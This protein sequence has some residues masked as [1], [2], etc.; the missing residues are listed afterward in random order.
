MSLAHVRAAIDCDECG[1]R[2][3]TDIDPA[4]AVAGY[5]TVFDVAIDSVRWGY[6]HGGGVAENCSVQDGRT[7]CPSC[8]DSVDA[9]DD[10]GPHE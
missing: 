3:Q 5:E 8:T 7:L 6:V 4:T 9:E 10:E 1:V 2:F